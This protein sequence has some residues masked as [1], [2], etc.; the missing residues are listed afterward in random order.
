MNP[1]IIPNDGPSATDQAAS[2]QKNI[3]MIL[4]ELEND[5]IIGISVD[6][7]IFGFDDNELKVLLIKSDLEK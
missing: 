5:G 7:V 2:G 6:C 3:K 4:R 1:E